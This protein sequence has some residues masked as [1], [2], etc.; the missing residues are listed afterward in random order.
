MTVPEFWLIADA[1]KPPEMVGK[2]RKDDFDRLHDLL[3]KAQNGEPR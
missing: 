1:K 3:K 2:I